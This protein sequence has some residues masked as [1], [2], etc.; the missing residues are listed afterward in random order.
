MS[1]IN[2]K[3]PFI[4]LFSIILITVFSLPNY[5]KA[6]EGFI[7]K[8][9]YFSSGFLVVAI[10]FIILGLN[11]KGITRCKIFFGEILSY[12]YGVF[13]TIVIATMIKNWQ[14]SWVALSIILSATVLIFVV[15][16]TVEKKFSCI[17]NW[18]EKTTNI[19]ANSLA[20]SLVK[21]ALI[22]IST[23]YI[24]FRFFAN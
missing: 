17:D 24:G 20:F 19:K 2:F 21:W 9:L 6:L 1:G 11:A 23:L 4:F 13:I 10:S 12:S 15:A 7:S 16:S 8:E 18:F 5:E 22:I 14:F 3:T